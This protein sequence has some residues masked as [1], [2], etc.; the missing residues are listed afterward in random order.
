MTE[1]LQKW[2][3]SLDRGGTFTD[4]W[5]VAPDGKIHVDKILGRNDDSAGTIIAAVKKILNIGNIDSIPTEI[6][7]SIRIGTTLV[8]NALLE[9]KGV[10]TALF[11]TEG[12]R[13]LLERYM[14]NLMVLQ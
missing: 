6:I 11:I 13:D 3:I 2:N 10:D 9:R 14:K 1:L 4:I 12:F 8:T 7:S 5:A